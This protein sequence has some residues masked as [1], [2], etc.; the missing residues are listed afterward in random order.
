M[1]EPLTESTHQVTIYNYGQPRV[2][3]REFAGLLM[4]SLSGQLQV[5]GVSSFAATSWHGQ[6]RVVRLV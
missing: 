5:S 1:R 2:G 6:P 3:N 4:G